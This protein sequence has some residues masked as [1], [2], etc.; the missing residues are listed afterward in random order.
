MVVGPAILVQT[1]SNGAGEGILRLRR[2]GGIQE[3]HV[4]IVLH[5]IARSVK[6]RATRRDVVGD[7]LRTASR[8][9]GGHKGSFN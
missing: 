3:T 7:P 4:S 9:H 6:G 5:E 1:G 8:I 2:S